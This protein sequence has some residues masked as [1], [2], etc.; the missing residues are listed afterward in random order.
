[1]STENHVAPFFEF[2]DRGKLNLGNVATRVAAWDAEAVGDFITT[3][4]SLLSDAQ[5]VSG[6]RGRT[7]FR[8]EANLDLSGEVTWCA[9]PICR[10]K[11]A[12][13][14]ARFV[15][16]YGDKAYVSNPF[17][18]YFH[19]GNALD[20]LLDPLM[21]SQSKDRLVGDIGVLMS[22]RPL[23]ESGLLAIRVDPHHI[24]FDCMNEVINS[25]TKV[26]VD[27]K[28]R[29]ERFETEIVEFY[30]ENVSVYFESHNE[31]IDSNESDVYDFKIVGPE[32]IFEH[33]ETYIQYTKELYPELRK[34]EIH[35]FSK[36][37]ERNHFLVDDIV[38]FLTIPIIDGM[39]VQ[40]YCAR[41]H[42]AQYLTNHRIEVD[43]VNRVGD[44]EVADISRAML[45]GIGH[46]V[47][48]IEFVSLGR[49]LKLRQ[50]EYEA[51][52]VYRDHL[53]M[54]LKEARNLSAVEMRQLID[55]TV[56]PEIH[57]ME[58]SIKSS[59]KLL[60]KS[61]KTDLIVGAGFMSI[62]LFAGLLP[63]DIAPIVRTIGASVGSYSAVSGLAKQVTMIGEPTKEVM[64]NPY[65][66][67]WK[68]KSATQVV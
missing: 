15:A 19:H 17:D 6:G 5:E 62:G 58:Q 48:N 32:T 39:L 56:R 42:N 36:P 41:L 68:A 44:Q 46:S 67:L 51:F 38:E 23:L 24:C 22:L 25:G 13:S 52:Q 61:V 59:K 43:I 10:I 37:L 8:F 9:N 57:K 34:L 30:R 65:Y 53:Y 63:P 14:L 2:L 20:H 29:L 40:D 31:I 27:I 49:L 60:T 16:L 35:D 64:E 7:L 33:G 18:K 11:K 12:D 45:E 50:N 21:I 3:A 54:A 66:F 4:H 55:D 26:S 28:E 1:M 47:P